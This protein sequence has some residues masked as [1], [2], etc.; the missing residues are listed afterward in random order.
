MKQKTTKLGQ[1]YSKLSN[2][3]KHPNKDQNKIEF[4]KKCLMRNKKFT[5]IQHN[6]CMD[7]SLRY[8][9]QTATLSMAPRSSS[10]IFSV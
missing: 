9:C 10:L 5:D 4:S 3:H 2:G 8:L 7:R 1:A 6:C